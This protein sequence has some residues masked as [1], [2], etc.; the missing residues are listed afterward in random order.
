MKYPLDIQLFADGGTG[1]DG[2]NPTPTPAAQ[3]GTQTSDPIDYEKLEGIVNRRS[4]VAGETAMKAYLKEQGMTQEEVNEAIKGYKESKIKAKEAEAQ[5]IASIEEENKQ[6]KA[7]ALEATQNAAITTQ[8]KGLGVTDEKLPFLMRLID[9]NTIV[10]DKGEIVEDK[11]KEQIEETIKSFPD[12]VGSTQQ[13][14]FQKVG[15]DGTSG[16]EDQKSTA[17][18]K[19]GMIIVPNKKG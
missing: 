12:F 11:I 2:G 6:L 10:D 16:G 5:R 19:N 9:K 17:A 14:G 4:G 7:Q 13:G 1:G 8:A 15:G 18:F 3:S